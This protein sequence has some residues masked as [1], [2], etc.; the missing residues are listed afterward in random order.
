MRKLFCNKERRVTEQ[1]VL[2]SVYFAL[3]LDNLLLTAVGW[4]KTI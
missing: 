3:L 2:L 1:F 4:L